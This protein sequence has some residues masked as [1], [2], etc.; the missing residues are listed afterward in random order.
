MK[1]TKFSKNIPKWSKSVLFFK[2]YICMHIC[3][4][5]PVFVN[6]RAVFGL[7]SDPKIAFPP[8]VA[9][10]FQMDTD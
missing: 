2:E 5:L 6:R 7:K 10:R 4:P 8:S 1:W 9:I 3:M